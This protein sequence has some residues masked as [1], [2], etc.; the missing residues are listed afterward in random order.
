MKQAGG[1]QHLTPCSLPPYVVTPKPQGTGR[2]T[3]VKPGMSQSWMGAQLTT[4]ASP[5]SVPE[6]APGVGWGSEEAAALC[7][8]A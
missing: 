3:H 4:L 7:P 6:A 2:G 5:Q 1:G 8:E